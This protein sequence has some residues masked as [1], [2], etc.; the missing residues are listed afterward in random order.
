LIGQ[1]LG[2]YRVDEKI[3]AG[4]MGEVFRAHDEH[5]E[6]DVAV[7]VLPAGT[8]ADESARK[9][10]R[11]E[12]LALS[13]LNHPN[14]ATI[15]DFDTQGGVDFLVMEHI[16]GV[17]LSERLGAGPLTEK[18]ITRLGMQ[19]A[20]GL[21]AAHSENII[22]RDLK[23]ANLRLTPDGRLKILD[24]GL[25]K[26]LRP[27]PDEAVTAESLSQSQLGA[28]AGTLP[29][30]APEQLRGEE[31]DA[32]TD[33]YAAGCV[34]YELAT[35]QR[36]FP[37][38]HG[39]RLID[40][41]LHQAPVPPSEL[42]PQLSPG[43]ETVILK[44]LD[45]EPDRRYQSARDLRADLDR[46]ATG[47]SVAPRPRQRRAWRLP[48]LAAGAVVLALAVLVGL[49]IG[50]MRDRL[51]DRS[52][53]KIESLAVLPLE[54]LSHDP[55][56]DYFA[57]G[58]TEALIAELSSISSLKVI[59]RTSAMQYKGARKPLPQIARELNV[60]ALVEGSVLRE[61]NRVRIN[62][63][64]YD[65]ATD[66]R[67]WG[68]SYERE[69]EGILAL[70]GEVA[71]AVVGEVR[72]ALTPREQSRLA[73]ARPV[74]PDAYE[75]YLRGRHLAAQWDIVKS[76]EYFDRAIQLDPTYAPAYAGQA[77][78]YAAMAF[79]ANAPP[80]D[81]YAKAKES[82]RK[83][84]ELDETLAEAHASMGSV[85]TSYDWDWRAAEREHRRAIE[86]N[87]SFPVAR[88]H[89]SSLLSVLGR[90]EE[91]IAEARRGRELDPLSPLMNVNL[92]WRFYSARDYPRALE[93]Y[94]RTLEL[95]P[96]Y[97]AARQNLALVYAQQG[98]YPESLAE[99]DKLGPMKDHPIVLAQLGRT[100][101]L[102]GQRKEA[103][104]VRQRIEAMS[105]QGYVS[106]YWTAALLVALGETDPVFARLEKAYAERDAWLIF[107]G[108]DPH[109][110]PIRSDARFQ[111]LLRRMNFPED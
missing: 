5:L 102:S 76:L 77:D 53:P 21:A 25:A 98:R 83:A 95:D 10:F 23:P 96:N 19:M 49:N 86:L 9:R 22:H 32:R 18:E 103:L 47:Q 108:G 43:L 8:L 105:K 33:I 14:I 63:Q 64:L 104:R 3:G 24:F 38:T 51:L 1:K 59:S 20:E 82:A 88:F 42:N 55:E 48:A 37:V 45:K 92:G 60:D 72:I 2:H 84:L 110:D 71:Q 27:T 50:G 81:F 41:I 79:A 107:L 90:H 106:P 4:G 39:P 40:A 7:K 67:I 34:L 89:Y 80:R 85:H 78:S 94:Q 58:M 29:Y 13:K 100:Y 57:D 26:L 62:V 70:Q 30:M 66:R 93:Q 6:R 52:A 101:A 99:F 35:R 109:F 28:A 31:V 17:A 46:L 15:F 54:N 111:A 73:A 97:A 36:P 65:G 11:K 44:A 91:A 61:R 56:Q 16:A 87:P 75:A 68:G 69:M 12:A 74:N